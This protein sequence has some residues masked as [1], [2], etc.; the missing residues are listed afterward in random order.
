MH[1]P[2]IDEGEISLETLQTFITGELSEEQLKEI[3]DKSEETFLEEVEKQLPKEDEPEPEP[4]EKEVD[5]VPD[6]EEEKNLQEKSKDNPIEK[7]EEVVVES[8]QSSSFYDNVSSM[9]KLGLVEDV[10][11]SLT[12]DEDDEGVLLSEYKDISED[13]LSYILEQQKESNKEDIESK[14]ISRDGLQDHHVK[15]IDILKNNGDIR[16]VFGDN[17]EQALKRPFEGMD[18]EDVNNQRQ[19]LLH[20]YINNK[21]LSQDDAIQLLGKK[22]KDLELDKTV[23]LVVKAYN[24]NY[25]NYLT[26]LQVKQ[27][28]LAKQRQVELKE[29]KKVLTSVLKEQK[30]KDSLVNKIV[31]AATEGNEVETKI[32]EI[33]KDPEKNHKLL[34]H[35]FDPESFNKLLQEDKLKSST[36]ESIRLIKNLPKREQKSAGNKKEN[37]T[38]LESY[39][40]E[41]L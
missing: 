38:S 6:K 29:K 2:S 35:L 3:D 7:E 22:E 20:H 32:K 26:D 21:Q 8:S 28:E 15:I 40:N 18:L 25:D 36:R 16:E 13:E 23:E 31:K 4:E 27:E 11:I 19:I 1:K 33:L 24:D 37:E 41:R 10:R 5:E 14:Y 9:L 30:I 17:P 34:L 12:D 39:L